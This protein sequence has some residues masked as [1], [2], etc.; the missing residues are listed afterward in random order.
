[1]MTKKD[2]ANGCPKKLM[3]RQCILFTECGTKKGEK[4]KRRRRKEI[5]INTMYDK[6]HARETSE[7]CTTMCTYDRELRRMTVIPAADD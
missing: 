5:Y 1:M 6:C 2:Y 3:T 7:R 4:R